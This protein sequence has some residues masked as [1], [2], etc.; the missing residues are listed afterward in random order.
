MDGSAAV[1]RRAWRGGGYILYEW[2]E[3]ELVGTFYLVAGRVMVRWTFGGCFI[4]LPMVRRPGA[5]ELKFMRRQTVQRCPR[6]EGSVQQVE[7]FGREEGQ[8]DIL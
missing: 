3:G 7:F 1:N 6:P 5:D 4:S 2:Y 8:P